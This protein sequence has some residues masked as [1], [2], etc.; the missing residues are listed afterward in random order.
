MPRIPEKGFLPS[1]GKL[2]ALEL[3]DG[4]GVR[5]DTGVEAGGEVTPFYDPMIAK[6]I[7]HGADARGGARPPRRRARP[8]PWWRDRRPTRLS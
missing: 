6:V 7:A 4:E 5:V 2:C 3:P 8:R 1:T